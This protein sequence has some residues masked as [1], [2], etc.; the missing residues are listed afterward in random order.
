MLQDV[1]DTALGGAMK[2]NAND[3]GMQNRKKY[4]SLLC[5]LYPHK[6]AV[7]TPLGGSTILLFSVYSMTAVEK[8]VCRIVQMSG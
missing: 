8:H 2:V 3:V 6:S 5:P 4:V 7:Q 1:S